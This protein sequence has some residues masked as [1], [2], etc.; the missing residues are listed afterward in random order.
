MIKQ[1]FRCPAVLLFYLLALSVC[2]SWRVFVE[3]QIVNHIPGY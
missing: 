3:I 1:S 2:E